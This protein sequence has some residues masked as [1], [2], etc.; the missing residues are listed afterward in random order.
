MTKKALS[1]FTVECHLNGWHCKNK[2]TNTKMVGGNVRIL[3][4]SQKFNGDEIMER[5]VQALETPADT[6]I[7]KSTGK[8]TEVLSLVGGSVKELRSAF[9]ERQKELEA[10]EEA[11]IVKPEPTPEPEEE[12]PKEPKRTPRPPQ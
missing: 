9:E 10:G 12:R 2:N 6:F 5:M 11:E 4:S 7:D 1:D 3:R 8:K